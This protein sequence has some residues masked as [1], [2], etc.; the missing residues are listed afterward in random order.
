MFNYRSWI[1][2]GMVSVIAGAAVPCGAQAKINLQWRASMDTVWVGELVIVGLYAVSDDD[3]E[4]ALAGIDAIVIWDQ[5]DL[6]LVAK[7]DV[8]P[9]PW[10]QSKFPPDAEIEGLNADC[11]PGEFCVPYTGL[12]YN[13]GDA[14]YQSVMQF[15]SNPP[16]YATPEGLLVTALVFRAVT[17]APAAQVG[18]LS[19]S[20]SQLT[21]VLDAVDLAADITGELGSVAIQVAACGTM[22][23]FDGSCSVGLADFRE[24]EACLT[25]P[26]DAVWGEGCEAADLDSDGDSDLRD[27]GQL[28]RSFSGP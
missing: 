13:D 1:A 22:G 4:Q 26:A 17:A 25:G 14:L 20:G 9:Y 6:V 21:V 5:A 7:Y 8:G 18:L 15:P 16:A 3:T 2:P 10:M 28:Q 12:P 23:D 19:A 27:V 11:S 24:F